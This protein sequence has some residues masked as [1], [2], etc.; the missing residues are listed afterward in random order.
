[1]CGIFALLN[2]KIIGYNRINEYF[3]IG[4]KR[5]PEYSSLYHISENIFYGFHRL[6]INGLNSKSNQPLRYKSY[7]LICNGEIYNYKQLIEKYNFNVQSDSDCEVILFLYE[8]MGEKCVQFLDGVFSFILYDNEKEELFVARD[9]MGVRPLYIAKYNDDSIGYCSDLKPLL[10]TEIDCNVL[11][12]T[13][14]TFQVLKLNIYTDKYYIFKQERYYDFTMMCNIDGYED[15]YNI[16]YYQERLYN[17]FINSIQKRVD[18]C[19]R[20]IACL[21]SGGL[22]SSLIAAIVS[23][24]Y[25][26]KTGNNIETYSIGLENAEDFKYAKMVARHIGSKHTEIKVDNIDFLMSIPDVIKD[27]ESYD[28]TTVRASVGNWNIGKYIKEHSEAKVI[29]NGD[30]ADELM[31][32]YLYFHLCPF[33]DEFDKEC[34][35]LL[36]DIS[37]YDV[38]RSDKGISS[39]G[40]EPR[41]PFL[42][43]EFVK[44]YLSIPLKYRCFMFNDDQCE[45][46]LIRKTI[47]IFEPNLLPKEVL[48]RTK[49]AF[50]DGVSG[51]N[52]S[53]YEIIDEYLKFNLD[54]NIKQDD[55]SLFYNKPT[56]DEQRWYR[57]IYDNHFNFKSNILPY[58]W[59]PKY[60]NA[61]DSSARTLDIYKIK[62]KK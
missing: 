41:T 21:L 34:K 24:F 32:G 45:K 57:K 59:M 25:K 29:F 16:Q 14:G 46:Y 28:T 37:H 19:E 53:W 52:K 4:K 17:L 47:E 8:M 22:D 30:G 31:G 36:R 5:G 44:F 12:F 61:T 60:T 40:L 48:W 49:E 56:T 2:N 13:P 20:P 58:F 3:M 10:F 23:R 11:Q 54:I 38:K 33:P 1:M 42:D 15:G 26:K 18:N 43:K 6:A 27:I 51:K 9:P 55:N 7:Y 39:H 62:N 50:S 35:R